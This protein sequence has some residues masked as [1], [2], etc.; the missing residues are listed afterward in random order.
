ME[1]AMSP[2]NL[3]TTTN[4]VEKASKVETQSLG[5]DT[6]DGKVLDKYRVTMETAG[7]KTTILQWIDPALKLPVKMSAE[8]SSWEIQY[9]NIQTSGVSDSLFEL[10]QGYTKF[11]MPDIKGMMS[12]FGKNSKK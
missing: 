12:G 4:A 6:V 10:P 11:Q 1:M 3:A 2:Q 7:Q 8:D 5:K 9:K